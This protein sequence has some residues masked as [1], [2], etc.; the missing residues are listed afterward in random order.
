ML[1]AAAVAAAG[2]ATGAAKR[3]TKRTTPSAAVASLAAG[4]QGEAVSIPVEGQ[5]ED[6]Q[7]AAEDPARAAP[8]AAA[9]AG[10]HRSL[11]A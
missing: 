6:H 3:T 10:G 1:A 7:E 9:V 2:V 4:Q 5:E 11:E 8:G